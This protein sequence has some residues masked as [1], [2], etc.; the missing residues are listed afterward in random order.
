MAQY[1]IAVLLFVGVL[2]AYFAGVKKGRRWGAPVLVVCFVGSLAAVY[3]AA[4]AK[5]PPPGPGPESQALYGYWC[6]ESAKLILLPGPEKPGA[7]ENPQTKEKGYWPAYECM[8]PDCPKRGEVAEGQPVLF[9]DKTPNSIAL[10]ASGAA[11]AAALARRQSAAVRDDFRELVARQIGRFNAR[12]WELR[13][14]EDDERPDE[15]ALQ[16]I[17]ARKK[18]LLE[19]SNLFAR[20]RRRTPYEELSPAAAVLPVPRRVPE[21]HHGQHPRHLV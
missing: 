2:G 18:A 21:L 9:A 13:L 12:L 1:A 15:Q 16:D 10:R 14:S 4:T 6:P 17:E 8:N 19:V 20:L 11:L 3:L 5:E 7:V